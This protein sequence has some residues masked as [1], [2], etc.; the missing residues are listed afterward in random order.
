M[1]RL[2]ER[3]AVL[4]SGFM[5]RAHIHIRPLVRERMRLLSLL[6]IRSSQRILD[7][8]SDVIPPC[9]DVLPHGLACTYRILRH[10]PIQNLQ[11]L[12]AG[13]LG[14]LGAF[15]IKHSKERQALVDGAKASKQEG[16][17]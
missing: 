1:R 4:N 12:A 14:T 15:K 17:P 16:V 13:S 10:D 2:T 3:G 9:F 8:A 7:R 6:E 11:M 5:L